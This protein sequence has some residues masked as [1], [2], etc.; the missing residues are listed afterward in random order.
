MKILQISPMI[1]VPP[2]NGGKIGIYGITKGLADIGHEIDFVTLLKKENKAESIKKMNEFCIPHIL[3]LTAE[4]SIWGAFKN[5]FSK[6]P[7]NISK[8][9]QKEIA[10]YTL[11]LLKKK[12]FDIVHID[13]LHLGWLVSVIKNEYNIPVVLRQHNV[14]MKIMERYAD[15]ASNFLTKIY[16]RIQYYKFKNY[17]P[18]LIEKFDKVIMITA[19]DEN[20]IKSFNQNIYTEVISVGVEKKF[21]EFSKNMVEEN[22]I[23][24][25]GNLD[26]PPNYDSLQW[27]LSEIFPLILARNKKIKL[28][29][30]GGGKGI[31]IPAHLKENIFNKGFVVDLWED[32]LSKKVAVVP[33]RIG[34]GIRIKIIEMLAAGLPMV[35]S[36]VG[37]EG[38][39][40]ENDKQIILADDAEKFSDAVLFLLNN[41]SKCN[42]LIE[43]GKNLVVE[44]Y[45]WEIIARQF[46]NS[47]KQL[48]KSLNN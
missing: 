42:S 46:E 21:L 3:D 28:Y 31:K 8:Y 34:S 20:C 14:E 43:N 29:I 10:V 19:K 6:V 26:W 45:T 27:F 18:W 24:H 25:I 17:E 40:C 9:H 48:I 7:Y 35:S 38:I 39:K 32:L 13:G 33:L 30:Y 36:S 47:Y 44:N 2:D 22:S 16:S 37:V 5:L 23:V 4:N 11:A 12:K 15:T 41:S 1:P